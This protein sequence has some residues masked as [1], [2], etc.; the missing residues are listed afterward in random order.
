MSIQIFRLKDDCQIDISA[1]AVVKAAQANDD[2]LIVFHH[3][4][5]MTDAVRFRHHQTAY[6][7][8]VVCKGSFQ[9]WNHHRGHTLGLG[10]FVFVPPG[11]VYGY[12][13]LEPQSEFI[14]LTTVH[15]IAGLG[16]VLLHD[17][18][19]ELCPASDDDDQ[20]GCVTHDIHF[21]QTH[22]PPDIL[23]GLEMETSLPAISQPYF[24]RIT[25]SASWMLGG[26][27]SRPCVTTAQSDGRFSISAME[28]SYVLSATPF[29][30]RWWCFTRVVHCF[31]LVQGVLKIKFKD[32]AE[33]TFVRQGQAI[34]VP[35]R[36][37][38]TVDPG[39]AFLRLISFSNGAGIDE[40]VC[41]AGLKRE[42]PVLPE[43]ASRWDAWDELRFR[44]ACVEVGAIISSA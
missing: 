21:Q 28:T 5:T 34:M 20:S 4:P 19:G 24:L 37:E 39:S 7:A 10:D 2:S 18:D 9:F 11:T 33:W 40:V 1:K 31:Y 15:D 41:K 38:F 8:F 30:N 27:I 6:N 14:I 32:D 43:A 22:L 36:Q 23:R 29:V 44:S 25:N 26:I 16:R 3:E 12:K 17:H 42:G 35:E 13:P